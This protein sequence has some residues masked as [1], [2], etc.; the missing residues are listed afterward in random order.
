MEHSEALRMELEQLRYNLS[1]QVPEMHD[2]FW[3]N[4]RSGGFYVPPQ[5]TEAISQVV[6]QTIKEVIQSLESRIKQA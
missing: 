2:G 3:I 4:T 1:Q 5:H 6:E